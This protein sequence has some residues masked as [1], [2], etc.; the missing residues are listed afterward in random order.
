MGDYY[1]LLGLDV[2]ASREQIKQAFRRQARLYHPDLHPNNPEAAEKFRQLRQAYEVLIDARQRSAY[3][4]ERGADSAPKSP[5]RPDTSER[6]DATSTVSPQVAYVRGVEKLQ[7]Q[8]YLAAL[9]HFGRA[10]DLDPHFGRAY[11][12][13]CEV[14]L[15]LGRDR[16]ILED[17]QNLL[18]L[19]PE[20][21]D[22]YYYRGR[23]RQHLGYLQAA[24]QAYTQALHLSSERRDIYYY[25]GNAHNESGNRRSALRDWR[26]YAE[27]CERH[28]DDIG[29]RSAM[30]ALAR[31]G[32]QPTAF[33]SRAAQALVA[34]TNHLTNYTRA[35]GRLLREPVGGMLPAYL[36]AGESHGTLAGCFYIGVVAASVRLSRVWS[37]M[38]VLSAFEG[39]SWLGLALVPFVGVL[40]TGAIAVSLSGKGSFSLNAGIFAA[41]ATLLPVGGLALVTS[42]GFLPFGRPVLAVATLFAF[43]WLIL[44]LYG[45]YTRLL[46]LPGPIATIA[47]PSA[48]A[49]SMTLIY[50]LEI[51]TRAV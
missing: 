18:K 15:N 41:G 20:N 2:D 48:I 33:G 37:G 36:G 42:I 5:V 51:L 24:I 46:K 35:A 47:T 27:L 30:D 31:H 6:S 39:W 8:D 7:Q 28:H 23:A 40:G 45:S 25:R 44:G 4:R 32:Q 1:Q 50:Y 9:E 3:D 38:P 13:R 19:Q 49:A 34:A 16:D 14:L 21:A 11:L 22:A 43:C 29:Y 10:L 26:R 12:K 17:C